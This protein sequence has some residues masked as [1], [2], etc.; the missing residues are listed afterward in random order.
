[1]YQLPSPSDDWKQSFFMIDVSGAYYCMIFSKFESNKS[2]FL[3]YDSEQIWVD[4]F[5][6]LFKNTFIDSD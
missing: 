6:A 3:K 1:M 2:L 5:I 4:N